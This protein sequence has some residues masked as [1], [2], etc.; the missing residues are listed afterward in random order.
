MGVLVIRRFLGSIVVEGR[1]AFII[2]VG[3][4]VLVDVDFMDLGE[5]VIS[6]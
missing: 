1:I 5:G 3:G 2:G 6:Y 4:V